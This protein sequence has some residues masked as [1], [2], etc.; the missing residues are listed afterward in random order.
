M[1]LMPGL[2]AFTLAAGNET[3]AA[4]ATNFWMSI[5]S[6]RKDVQICLFVIELTQRSSPNAVTRG[7]RKL[8]QYISLLGATDRTKC[9]L[10]SSSALN[11]H[12]SFCS[13]R[14]QMYHQHVQ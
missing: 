2:H 13:T 10:T 9:T 4:S 6:D 11:A 3:K 12:P 7:R 8:M 5:M 14:C 1:A